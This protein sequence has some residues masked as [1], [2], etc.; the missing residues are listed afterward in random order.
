MTARPQ[1][2]LSYTR[3]DDEAHDGG[4]TALRAALQVQ[5]R[6]VTG[7]RTF[8]IFQD[9]EGIAFGQHWPTA[10]DEALAAARF[11]VPVLSPAFFR[12]DPCRDELAKFLA[13]EQ[14]AGR[15]DLILPL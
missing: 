14:A 11:L 10:L 8:E 12:S 5:V 1:V 4:I 2:F 6:A 13:H 15:R 7:D 3:L 9:I